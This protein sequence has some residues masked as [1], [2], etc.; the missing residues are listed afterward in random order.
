MSHALYCLKHLHGTADTGQMSTAST[1]SET[2]VLFFGSYEG[3][4][5][6]TAALNYKLP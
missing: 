4:E 6:E 5:F 2:G 1:E 3:K